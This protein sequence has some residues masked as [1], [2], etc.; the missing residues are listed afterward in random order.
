MNI[1]IEKNIQLPEKKFGRGRESVYQATVERMEVG[2]SCA[3]LEEKHA[4]GL[5]KR[6]RDTGRKGSV[7]KINGV[8]RVWRV[9]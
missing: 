2:D 6:L 8:F 1:I 9:E 7:R 3:F 5:A 4:M